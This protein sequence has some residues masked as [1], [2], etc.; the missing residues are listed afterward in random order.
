MHFLPVNGKSLITPREPDLYKDLT[1]VEANSRPQMDQAGNAAL[2]RR[3]VHPHAVA[4]QFEALR[5]IPRAETVR[6]R[7]PGLQAPQVIS[8][9]AFPSGGQL[10]T[11]CPA[12]RRP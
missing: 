2:P 12:N 7:N 6:G 3:G 11:Q 9:Q 8:E 10:K 5:E 1:E 4:R